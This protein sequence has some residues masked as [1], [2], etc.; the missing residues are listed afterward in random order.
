VSGSGVHCDHTV[1]LRSADSSLRLDIGGLV[2]CYGHVHLR[3]VVFF[4]FHLEEMGYGCANY[5]CDISRTVKDIGV[6]LL[7]SANRKSYAAS[8]GTTTDDLE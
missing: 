4:Q 5:R 7:L 2:Q 6:K 8:I 1:Q 3:P